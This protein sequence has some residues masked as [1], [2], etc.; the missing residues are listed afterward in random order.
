MGSK[1]GALKAGSNSQEEET[2]KDRQVEPPVQRWSLNNKKTRSRV[3]TH[4]K[5]KKR[6]ATERPPRFFESRPRRAA[7]QRGVEQ[8]GPSV[9]PPAEGRAGGQRHGLEEGDGDDDPR[10]PLG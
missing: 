7:Q 2:K 1:G 3:A 9:G 4:P 10:N 5:K 6:E 8:V